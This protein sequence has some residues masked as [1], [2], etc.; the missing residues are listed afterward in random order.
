MKDIGTM[1]TMMV[2]AGFLAGSAI[3][4]DRIMA[5][6]ELSNANYR[7]MKFP[8]ITEQTLA[9]NHPQLQDSSSADM[10]DFYGPCDESPTGMEQVVQ[11]KV[12]A[13]LHR[14]SPSDQS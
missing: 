2:L 3:A 5:K 7:H 6:D 1:V 14:L 10:I 9:G 8:A 13:R 12:K 4:K 11:Q